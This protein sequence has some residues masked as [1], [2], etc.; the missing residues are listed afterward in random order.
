LALLLVVAFRPGVNRWLRLTAGLY[1]LPALCTSTQ[2]LARFPDYTRVWI[3]LASLA[4]IGLI[5][6]RH[7]LA[8][9][10]WVVAS[11]LISIAYG[12]GYWQAP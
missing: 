8:M 11:T 2:I 6:L 9:G 7:K 3:D 4:L 12:V 5:S 10:S 1:V